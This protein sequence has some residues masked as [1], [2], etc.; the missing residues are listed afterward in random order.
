MK[1]KQLLF[2]LNALLIFPVYGCS[3]DA[4][5]VIN[6]D[7]N[8]VRQKADPI[9]GLRIAWDRSSRQKISTN[10]GYSGYPRVK[11]LKDNSICAVY[12]SPGGGVFQRSTD[13]G[14]KWS[15]PIKMFSEHTVTNNLGTTT[16][17]IS[18]TE[19]LELDDHSIVAAC[20]YRPAI[21]DITPFAIAICKSKDMGITWTT[22]QIIYEAA[23]RFTDGCWEPAFLQL[24]NGDLQCYF[25]NENPYQN[26]A[27]QEISVLTSKNRGDTWSST[28][29]MVCFRQDH[30]DGMPVPLLS[31][32]SILVAIEDNADGDF[33]PAIVRCSITDN[34][35]TPVYQNSRFR[36]FCLAEP[37]TSTR[38]GGAPYIIK[39]PSGEILLSYQTQYGRTTDWELSDME[40]AIGDPT[41]RNFKRISRPFNIDVKYQC[42]WN[43]LGMWDDH[44][45]VASGACNLDGLDIAV[46]MICGHLINDLD[47]PKTTVQFDGTVSKEEYGGFFPYFSGNKTISN[48]NAAL[49][50]VDGVL[51]V[52]VK[53]NDSNKYVDSS[54]DE[55]SDGVNFY[56]DSEN[57][58]LNSPD[59]GIFKIWC[60]RNGKVKVYEG[61]KGKWVEI[62]IAIQAKTSDSGTSYDLEYKIPISLIQAQKSDVMRVNF[63]WRNYSSATAGY[64]E[65]LIESKVTSSNTFCKIK[66]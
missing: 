64:N 45:I 14:K 56:I 24:P 3:K 46:W 17:H 58:C 20:N 47:V 42:K 32:D 6:T 5:D 16:V 48:L 27:E 62:S 23:P 41:G 8:Y 57:F 63:E 60:S 52:G 19:F 39:V 66:L 59:K 25:A 53:V 31:D 65:T 29:K 37:L 22:P 44:S 40:V 55:K 26:S 1:F 13:G 43:S 4:N 7:N 36:N 9:D 51:Y 10:S 34:W 50:L 15:S 2:L 11:R 28:K 49:S 54:N 61:E 33:R 35:A 12:E 30:R 18:N 38:H 21:E